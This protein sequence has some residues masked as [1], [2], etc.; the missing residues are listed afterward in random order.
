[1]FPG[2]RAA[3]RLP[4]TVLLGGTALGCARSDHRPLTGPERIALADTLLTVFD[5]VGAIHRTHPDTGL[6]RRLHPEADTLWYVEGNRF[7]RLTGDSL[8]RRVRVL[9]QPVTMMDQRFTDRTAQL[10]DRNGAILNATEVV[11][12][13]D[14]Q[15]PHEFRGLMTLVL[16]RLGSRWVIRA[17][18]G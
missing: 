5:S 7:E 18:R 3:W 2:S 15:G 11:R 12:W 1:M 16:S 10:L 6:L 17:Y 14:A 8:F 9:H 4:F 13:E